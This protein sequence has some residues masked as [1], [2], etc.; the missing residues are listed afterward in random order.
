MGVVYKAYDPKINRLV[1]VKTISLV[2]PA[3]S[4]Q[5]LR[6]RIFREAEAAGRLS[7]PRIV[8]VF[9]I[10]EEADT[11]NPYIVMEYVAGRSLEEILS[12]KTADLPLQTTLRWIQEVA[13]ALDYAHRNGVVHRDVKPSNILIGEDGHAKIADFGISQLNIGDA[14]RS[15][16]TWGTPAYMSPEQVKGE[17]V[18]G[19]SDLFSLG[20]VLYTVLAGHR[21]FQGNSANTI[22]V[23][24]VNGDPVP[25]TAFNVDLAPEL[26]E[27]IARAIA[28]NPAE[29]YQTGMEMVRAL[30]RLRDDGGEQIDRIARVA[31][32][33]NA[34]SNS[35]PPI[36]NASVTETRSLPQSQSQQPA[37]TTV[38]VPLSQ[39]WQQAG[40]AF[41]SLGSLILAFLGLWWAIPIS[42]APV[43]RNAAANT[44]VALS[45]PTAVSR[46]EIP[47]AESRPAVEIPAKKIPPT[48]STVQSHP[49]AAAARSC[50]LGIAVE[51]HFLTADLSIWIDDQERYSH[52]LRGAVNKRVVFFKGVKGYLSDVM[53]VAP[54][55]HQIRVRVLSADGS[56]DESGSISGTFA[57]GNEKLLDVDFDKDNRRMRLTFADDKHF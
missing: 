4:D 39:P 15:G 26:D 42:A 56:Y 8:C 53:P 7:H 11:S 50:Q 48:V 43:V 38:A 51:H 9:D 6:T 44:A 17:P 45:S 27:V 22:S 46:P 16:R 3:E 34:P 1:A 32:V 28:K 29:R 54:G 52:S 36:A 33:R 49:S 24:I 2:A 57:P 35:P 18:D 5:A 19:R 30:Q 41:L 37:K 23:R 20:V 31:S 21:P 40:V 13:E 12:T 14:N 10:G 55:N 25:V 47:T